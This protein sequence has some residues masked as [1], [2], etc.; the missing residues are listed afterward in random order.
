MTVSAWESALNM[1]KLKIKQ[2]NVEEAAEIMMEAAAWLV[3]T[4]QPLWRTEDL[5]P[6]KL[7]KGRSEEA[8]HVG[9]ED[10]KSVAAMILQWHDPLFW[11]EIK[12]FESGFIHKLSVR[13]A[14]AGKGY[15]A[16]LIRHAELECLKKGINYLRL[17]CAGDRPKLCEVY[18]KLGFV[19][20]DRNMRMGFDLAFYEKRISE[21]ST[22]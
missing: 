6:E 14:Y 16:E 3:E 13:R 22:S 10:D 5:T 2:G 15:V 17:D 4:G 18:E 21:V 9:W 7:L 1:T 8:F 12:P 20:V 19:Q 11:K